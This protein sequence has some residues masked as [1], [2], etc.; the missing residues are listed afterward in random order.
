MKRGMICIKQ[1]W[2]F[3]NPLS[4]LQLPFMNFILWVNRSWCLLLL[5]VNFC[6]SLQQFTKLWLWSIFIQMYNI[7]PPLLWR[8]CK[9]FIINFATWIHSF[10]SSEIF[11]AIILK[12]TIEIIKVQSRNNYENVSSIRKLNLINIGVV[13]H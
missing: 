11:C 12:H 13:L 2:H 6:W 5:A 4:F 1:L 10:S 8:N 7:F 9:G 3:F